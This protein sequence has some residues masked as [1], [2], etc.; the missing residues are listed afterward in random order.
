MF[1]QLSTKSM[2]MVKEKPESKPI[3][4]IEWGL[5]MVIKSECQ[6]Q[7]IVVANWRVQH[8]NL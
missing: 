5:L 3:M 7:K 4:G 6:V 2:C 8:T 1:T